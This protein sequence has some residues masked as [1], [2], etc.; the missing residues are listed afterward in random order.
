MKNR[1]MK[2]ALIGLFAAA[3]PAA[4]LIPPLKI[5]FQGKLLDP[6]TN[7]PKNGTFSM[8]FKIYA[9]QTAGTALYTET[10][11]NVVVSN[12]V[13]AVQIG[14]VTAL[15]PSLFAGTS[16]YLGITVSP[17]AEMTPLQQLVMVPYA[18]TATQL[19]SG[20]DIVINPGATAYSTFTVAGNLL[21]PG[22]V[23]ASSASFTNGVTASSGTFTAS[24]PN[25]FSITTS[26]GIQMNLGVL[27]V[28]GT[29]GI[30]ADDTGIT[31]ST[32]D[33]TG[34]AT[35]PQGN[36]GFMYYNTSTGSLKVFDGSGAWNYAFGQ[37]L[38][39]L[40]FASTDN[41]AATAAK[42]AASTILLV[43]IYL[44]GPMMV[45]QL[46]ARVTTA[47]GAA[48]D[49]GIYSLAGTLLLNGGS[50]SLST[51]TGAKT[52]APTQTGNARFLPPGQYFAAVTWNSTT[53]VVGGNN[54]TVAGLINGCGTLTGG[55]LVLPAAITPG[56][57][58]AGTIEPF[59]ELNP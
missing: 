57:I 3:V 26:S 20:Q 29:S 22:G 12:G 7:L 10:Q 14:S 45:N 39:R 24:G 56:S 6:A 13:F 48:G 51:T 27:D 41:T 2:G 43:P 58:T 19:S 50:S 17:D 44:P 36:A 25:Q 55:G 37:S 16:A 5:N 35:D 4:A 31:L 21:L 49:V 33:F 59:V 18:F 8:T 9:T 28:T 32:I 1:L 42:A 23:V 34:Q 11:P 38:S 40:Y 15:S 30:R 52:I 47:L 46:R 53:G 54:L